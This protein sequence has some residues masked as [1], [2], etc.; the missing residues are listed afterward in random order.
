MDSELDRLGE[1]IAEQAAHL[2]AATYQLLVN[3]R[4]F[5]ERGGWYAQGALSCAHW[6]SWRVGWTLATARDRVR[7]ANKLP[8]VPAI[9]DALRRGEVSYSKVR[10]MLRIATPANEAL[11]LDYARFMTASQVEETCRKYAL[12]LR[13][14]QDP[15]PLADLQRRYVR[16][17]DT[18]DGMVKIE[19]VIHPEE[20]ELI[21]TM[22]T[23]AAGQLV[24]SRDA[25][26]HDAEPTSNNVPAERREPLEPVPGLMQM[27]QGV[28][29]RDVSA[30]RREPLEP[31]PG[32]MQMR[33]GVMARDVS[34][35]RREPLEP[36]SAP[37]PMGQG[38]MAR[39]VP[40]ERHESLEPVSAP[41]PMGQGVMARDVPAERHESLELVAAPMPLHQGM[42]A[43]DVPVE[44][45]ESMQPVPPPTWIRH[46][47]SARAVSAETEQASSESRSSGSSSGA[48][49]TSESVP[50]VGE[51]NEAPDGESL[52]DRLLIEAEALRAAEDV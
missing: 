9:S 35:E 19:A 11:L 12:V 27:R 26:P 34:A 4:E 51:P 24:R 15:H 36:V 25:S 5:D 2:D 39:D 43:N 38:V 17:R 8:E 3:L 49:L 42:I 44:I 20:A 30:E 21:W 37:M 41:M 14:G 28:M 6:L 52:L 22:L 10:A 13:H 29:A 45:P 7:V 33:Q 23:H 1:R 47:G 32:L 50:L 18:E 48:Q 40:A 16:R 46:A 31:V